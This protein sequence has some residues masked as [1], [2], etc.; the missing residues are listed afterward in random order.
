MQENKKQ[1]FF[2]DI[3]KSIKDFDKYEDFIAYRTGKSLKYI[4]LLI[5]F[6]AFVLYVLF[7][8]KFSISN[9]DGILFFKQNILNINYT[10]EGLNL[11]N[12]DEIIIQNKYNFILPLWIYVLYLTSGLVDVVILAALGYIIAL[13]SRIKIPYKSCFNLAVH[14]FT[15][16]VI[17]EIIYVAVNG[18]TGFEIKYFNLMYTCISYIYMIV[19]ILMIKTELINRQIELAKIMQEQEKNKEDFEQEPKQDN[20]EEDDEQE[21]QNNNEHQLEDSDELEEN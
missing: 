18:L 11:E 14:S 16:P 7:L 19:A 13:I 10:Q 12:I 8:Y 9:E 4:C 1:G 17:L 21:N 20:E 6:L 15:L 5:L 3:I 2:A